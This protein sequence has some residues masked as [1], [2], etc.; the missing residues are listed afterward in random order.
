MIRSVF[1]ILWGLLLFP[2]IL[3]S[4]TNDS[5]NKWELVLEDTG[6]VL[7]TAI[8]AVAGLTTIIKK[9]W[10]G[11]KQFA[12]SYAANAIMTYSLKGIIDKQ[13]PGGINEFDAFPSGHTS[14]AFSGASFIQ[15]RY[16]WKYGKYAYL[17]A[18]VTGVS[19]VEG[20]N[21]RHD[22]WD[23]LAGALVGI[24]TTYIFTKP[25][26]QEKIELSFNSNGETYL[27]S[28]NYRF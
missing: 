28:L 1:I 16:G 22:Y 26:Q 23:V 27:L 10:Q 24:G 14:S 9:D 7:M 25:Y 20:A 12:L 15:R 3:Q 18:M 4:Q 19:R 11:T 6:D 21:R 13:R 8:P 2:F 5:H 17:L